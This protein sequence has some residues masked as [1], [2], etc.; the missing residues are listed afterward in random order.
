MQRRTVSAP[1]PEG[2]SGIKN[3]EPIVIKCLSV[4]P[5][6]LDCNQSM[7]CLNNGMFM[8]T[9]QTFP[10]F[11]LRHTCRVSDSRRLIV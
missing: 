9:S 2:V 1:L 8:V 7:Q 5:I 10:V 6:M 11:M 4:G 3:F